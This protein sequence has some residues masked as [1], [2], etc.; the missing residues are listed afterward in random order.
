MA[1][2]RSMPFHSH[3]LAAGTGCGAS[4]TNAT[5]IRAVNTRAERRNMR[6]LRHWRQ[7]GTASQHLYHIVYRELGHRRARF[8]GAAGQMRDEKDIL[9]RQEIGVD[10]RL[11][12]VDVERRAGDEMLLEGPGQRRFVHYWPARG[13]NQKRRPLH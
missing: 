8:C 13:I 11:L 1:T 4:A 2:T 3:G 10:H 9:E 12:L 5:N 6:P 7:R